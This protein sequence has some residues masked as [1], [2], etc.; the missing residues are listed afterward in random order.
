MIKEAIA[1]IVSRTNLTEKEMKAA[2]QEIMNGKAAPAQIAAFLTGLRTKGETVEEL[3]AAC[4]VMRQFLKPIATNKKVILDTCGTGGDCKHTFNISTVSAIVVAACGI[5][6]AKHGNR[7]VSSSCGS[8]D[9]LEGLGVNIGIDENRMIQCLER[10]GIAFLFAPKLHPAMKYATPVRREIGIRT[11]FNVLGPLSNPASAT[12][13]LVGVYSK[14]LVRPI[15]EVLKNIGLKHA[16]VVHGADG[17]DEIT[18]TGKTFAC[19]VKNKRVKSLIINPKA[20]GI[21]LAKLQ[22]LKGG[23]VSRNVSIAR[24]VLSGKKSAYRD[25]V[26][27]NSAFAIYVADKIKNIK[28]AVK[29]AEEVID[30]GKAK[31]KL[32]HLREFTTR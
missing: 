9:L 8:A 16:L 28:L 22:S 5:T 2:M 17:L 3:T 21:K 26:V 15:A 13:Q 6:V 7:S 24:S 20:Y 27:L 30:T 29:I 10:I 32:E 11:I 12:H 14:E 4:N 25:I 23:S 18:T 19:E 1:K 31:I